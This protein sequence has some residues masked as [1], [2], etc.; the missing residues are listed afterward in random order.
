MS[1]QT[2]FNLFLLT[3]FVNT[4]IVFSQNLQN[5][6]QKNILFISIDDLKPILCCYGNTK[7]V[8]PNIDRLASEGTVFQN[9]HCQQAVCGPSR[10]SVL[11]GLRPDNTQVWELF[12]QMREANPNTLTLPEYLIQKGYE[13][14]GSGKVLDGSCVDEKR[15]EPSWSIPFVK[16]KGNRWIINAETERF[17]AKNV[18]TEAPDRPEAEFID[19]KIV[20]EGLKL[21]DTMAKG[22]KPFFLAVGIKK[23]HLPFIAPKKYWDLYDR[24][25]FE[26]AP[27]QEHHESIPK[28]AFQPS[29]E[30]RSG[31]TS[32]PKT[33]PLP[34][35]MQKEFIHGYYACVS[36]ADNQVGRLLDALD[37]LS[38]RE[39]TI[40]VL[41]SDHGYHLGDHLMWNKFTEFESSTNS[42]LI[43][44]APGICGNNKTISPTELVDIFPTL[45]ELTG[46]EKPNNLD[47]KSLVPI[48][49]DGR[50][51][52]KDFAMTQY[53]RTTKEGIK[54]EGYSIK[55]ERYRYTEWI[56][57]MFKSHDGIY[58]EENV[59]T[60][61][62]YDY[63][64][65]PLEKE[66][67]VNKEKYKS[68]VTD[69]KE[70]MKKYFISQNRY[71]VKN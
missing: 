18:P 12:T 3:F 32:I 41:W 22:D 26:I 15:D 70:K 58:S 8:S 36:H 48:L 20:D 49:K 17:N 51:K 2:K 44:S 29:W 71:L 30:L 25:S 59:Y 40:I 65:D 63:R 23:P 28:F 47:G 31:Y 24:E 21:L 60:N 13:T 27:V 5:N 7:I 39:N 42:P 10:A 19:A 68:V 9:N 56:K 62:F 53:H 66:N 50:A 69:M 16:P 1:I 14:A 57:G 64:C 52:V 6:N 54:L 38:I 45:C 61:E 35:A 4:A 46:I 11:T 33:D 37:S 67:F 43:I 55:T 34:V